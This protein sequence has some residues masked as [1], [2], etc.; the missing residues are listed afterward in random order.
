MTRPAHR[1][2]LHRIAE[3]AFRDVIDSLLPEPSTSPDPSRARPDAPAADRINSSVPLVGR[4]LSGIVQL[5]LPGAFLHRAFRALTGL[6]A[7]A[8]GAPALLDDAAGELANM[9]AGRVAARLAAEGYPCDLGNPSV[10][11]HAPPRGPGAAPTGVDQGRA[12]LFNEGH[13]LSVEIDCR[14]AN[15]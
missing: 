11:R 7:A 3:S 5:R 13:W 4:A 12:D 15:V 2:D 8:A 10:S 14:F 6:E 9:V 1:P